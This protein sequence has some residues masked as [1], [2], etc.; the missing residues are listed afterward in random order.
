MNAEAA[1]FGYPGGISG[2]TISP[3]DSN[4]ASRYLISNCS[5][6]AAQ[7]YSFQPEGGR[8]GMLSDGA[9]S[10]PLAL[11]Y[12]TNPDGTVSWV[13]P[14]SRQLTVLTKWMQTR[15]AR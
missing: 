13:S 12:E 5:F 6:F 3:I 4:H 11:P 10:V 7:D 1:L 14:S 2:T 15:M 9:A 8:I